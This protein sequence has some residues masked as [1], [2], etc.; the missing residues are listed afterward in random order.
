MALER[1]LF[2]FRSLRPFIRF[3]KIFFGLFEEFMLIWNDVEA[4]G[5]LLNWHRDHKA[6][7]QHGDATVFEVPFSRA[8]RFN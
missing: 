1:C 8:L 7:Q 2:C 4:T 6:H 5:E 3:F